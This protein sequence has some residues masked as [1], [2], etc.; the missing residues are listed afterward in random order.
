M[1][2]AALVR[3][4]DL[5]RPRFSAEA[6]QILDMM[7]ALA[8]DCSLDSDALHAKA[9]ADTG[10][11]DFGEGDYRERL[12][13]YLAAL[14]EIDGMQPA[15]VVNFYGQLLQLLKNRLLLSDLRHRHPEIDDIE[16]QPPVVIAGLPRT[17]TTHLH[18]MLAAPT[19]FR[20]MPYWESVEP[21]PLRQEAG[22]EPDPRRVRMDVAVGV[23]NTVMPHFALMHEMTADHVHEEIQLLANDFSTML[24]ET[25][26]HVPRWRDYYQTHDQTPHYQYLATQLKAMQFLR[27]GRRWLLKSPQHLEQVPVLD[28][29][30]PGSIVLF[31]HRDPVP[32][33]L[34]ML[35]M[36]TYSARMHRWPVPVERIAHYWVDRLDRMLATLVRDRDTIGPERSI[37]IRFDD[38]MADEVGV[39]ERIYALAGEP[40]TDSVRTATA[41]YLAGHQRGR[42]G[43]VQTSCEMF[44]LTEES[45]RERF[46]PYLKRFLS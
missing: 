24:F 44:G 1:T 40:F 4:D 22:V 30:F 32:V 25:L 27:G 43:A 12:D 42:L 3:L 10:L 15:G 33:A 18:N 37:D 45:L 17:G 35:A 11:H 20:T 9:S 8:P 39:A 41:G 16:L 23:I 28:R 21:F 5:S 36:I 31:T 38:F 13:V 6:Q 26:G 19:T 29:V 46:A 14:A 34:S 2:K 7:A